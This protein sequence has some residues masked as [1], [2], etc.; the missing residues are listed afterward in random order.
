MQ[1]VWSDYLTSIYSVAGITVPST[2]RV[3]VTETDY[4]KKLVGLLDATPTRTL[5]NYGRFNTTK[6][7]L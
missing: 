4:L 7:E 1:I 6:T 2:E 3:I 5:G